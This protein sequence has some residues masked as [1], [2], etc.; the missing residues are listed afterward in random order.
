MHCSFG[1]YVEHTKA[2][3]VHCSFMSYV[4]QIHRPTLCIV[5]SATMSYNIGNTNILSMVTQSRYDKHQ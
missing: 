2:Y 4:E 1:S 5:A 3:I